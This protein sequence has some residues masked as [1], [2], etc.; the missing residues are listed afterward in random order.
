MKI[1]MFAGAGSV[2]KTQLMEACVK[3]AEQ[4]GIRAVVHKSTTRQTYEK[5]GFNKE[6]DALANLET[7]RW[8]QKEVMQDNIIALNMAVEDAEQRGCQILICDRTP[9]DYAAYQFTVFAEQ[10]T[11]HEI[12]DKQMF[13][14]HTLKCFFD[15]AHTVDIYMLPFPC[16]WSRDTQSSDGWRHDTTGKNFLWS[17]AVES[18]VM[19]IKR[20]LENKGA[21]HHHISVK[22]LNLF[23]DK[24]N[25]DVRAAII[26]GDLFADGY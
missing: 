3:L 11:I 21:Y 6:R 1:L 9:H 10:M 20:R 22:H 19:N 18:T 24:A 25:P 26:F 14:D 7:N 8:F 15:A 23:A 13:A 4:H 5:H 16:Y 12:E 2:G 17:C